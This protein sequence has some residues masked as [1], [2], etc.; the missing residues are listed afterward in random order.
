MKIFIFNLIGILLLI[1]ILSAIIH[2]G[3][4]KFEYVFNLSKIL[5][6]LS[7]VYNNHNLEILDGFQNSG[8]P[9]GIPSG[10][11]NMLK[12]VKNKNSCIEGY[13]V[14]GILDTY[15]NVLCIDEYL[16]CPIN[17]VK[18]DHINKTNVKYSDYNV[19]DLPHLST[20]YKLFYKIDKNNKNEN[21]IVSMVKTKEE[22]KYITINNFVLDSDAFEKYFGNKDLLKSIA[23]IFGYSEEKK[24]EEIKNNEDEMIKVIEIFQ[25]LTENDWKINLAFKAAKLFFDLMLY[26]YN[27]QVKKFEE[28]IKQKIEE[29]EDKNIDKYYISIGDNL[30][31]KNY[32]GFK[33]EKDLN[34][35]MKF[36][37]NIY[38]KVFPNFIAFIFSIISIIF[39]CMFIIYIVVIIIIWEDQFKEDGHIIF[40]LIIIF[41]YYLIA[42]GFFIYSI[43]I[44]VK[45]NNNKTLNELKSV[46]SDEFINNFINEFVSDVKKSNLIISTISITGACLIINI[47][48]LTYIMLKKI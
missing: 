39:L 31:I 12:L 46:E 22:P 23:N 16:D 25:M 19:I 13:K 30:Y 28:F 4:K 21:A 27:K 33:S 45:V 6:V 40:Y 18:A 29:F 42:I 24:K 41:L 26:D 47:I 11:K 20:N 8:E 36:D 44:Y 7:I 2:E 37:Y 14:C 32:I 35:F 34:T 38:K 43:V 9:F 48:P 1:G 10:Y 15:G 3:S 17:N 5:T